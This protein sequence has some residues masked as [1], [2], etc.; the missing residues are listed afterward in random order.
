LYDIVNDQYCIT[1]LYGKEEYVALAQEMK[2]EL[3][4]E[5]TKTNDP[6]I[7]GPDKEIFDSYLRYDPIRIFPKPIEEQ[8]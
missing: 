5:L 3:I 4:K 6:R 8:K 1:N 2:S 7:V